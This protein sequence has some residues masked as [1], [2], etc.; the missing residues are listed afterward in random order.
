MNRE[1]TERQINE[2][3]ELISHLYST[4]SYLA[5]TLNNREYEDDYE[6]DKLNK[7]YNRITKAIMAAES[8]EDE[9][10]YN[11]FFENFPELE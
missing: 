9:Y 2:V 5:S 4:R 6:K 1:L 3:D 7:E 11:R 8:I 10:D